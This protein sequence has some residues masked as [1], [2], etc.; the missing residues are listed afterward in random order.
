LEVQMT[1]SPKHEMS[2]HDQPSHQRPNLY[3]VD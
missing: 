3:G 2:L 1:I